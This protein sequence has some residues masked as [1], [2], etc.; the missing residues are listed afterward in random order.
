MK[1]NSIADQI[2]SIIKITKEQKEIDLAEAT[3][4]DDSIQILIKKVQIEELNELLSYIEKCAK[5][6]GWENLILGR[7]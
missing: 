7:F 2:L 1:T 6:Q 3:K 4:R 5:N